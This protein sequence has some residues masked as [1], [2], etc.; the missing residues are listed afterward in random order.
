MPEVSVVV[1]VYNTE[2]YVEEAVRSIMEQT[3]AD[4]EIIAVDDGSTDGSAAVLER[5]AREDSRIR[6][7]TQPNKGLSEARNAG[8]ARASGRYLYFMDSDDRLESDALELCRDKCDAQRLDF[9]FFDADTFGADVSD[10]PWFDYH[11]AAS[12]EDR[13]YTGPELLDT[14]LSMRKY[15]A[16]ACLYMIRT[17]WLLQNRLSFYPRILH[18]DELFTT[19]VFL[20]AARVGRIERSFFKRRLRP[21]SIMGRAFSERNL[22]GYLTVLREIRRFA[23]GRG[24]EVELLAGRFTAYLLGPVLRNAWSLPVGVRLRLAT[25]VLV[26]YPRSTSMR[27]VAFML[28]KSPLKKIAGR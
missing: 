6:I 4:I 27:D 12:F 10:C 14:M 26:H 7:H 20:S 24:N 13:I 23:A 3:L 18:E 19:T 25:T 5:L 21:D 8:I 16:S 11:R 17:E 2:I 9:V 22:R 1:P 28:L 15:I